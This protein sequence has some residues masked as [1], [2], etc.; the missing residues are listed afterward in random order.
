MQPYTKVTVLNRHIFLAY[1]F[2]AKVKKAYAV[3]SNIMPLYPLI[4]N[5]LESKRI[6]KFSFSRFY[7]TGIKYARLF[8]IS[9]VDVQSNID[10]E[11]PCDSP[12]DFHREPAPNC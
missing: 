6:E 9:F 3:T 12:Q 7:V 4:L 2:L 10:L 5:I 11:R 1:T 8:N